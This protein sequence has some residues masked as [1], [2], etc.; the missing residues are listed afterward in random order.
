MPLDRPRLKGE[1]AA[2]KW[3]GP[4]DYS[5][6]PN[7]R[8]EAVGPGRNFQYDHKVRLREY[9]RKKNGGLLRSDLDGSV[10]NEPSKGSGDNMQAE[11]DHRIPEDKGGPNTSE[12]AQILSKGQNRHKS[13]HYPPWR[14]FRR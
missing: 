6:V 7:P 2:P 1:A 8:P 13:A 11:V 3:K 5:P 10:L 14:R 4:I 12:N 9:N